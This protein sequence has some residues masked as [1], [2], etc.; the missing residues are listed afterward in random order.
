MDH[1]NFQITDHVYKTVGDHPIQ[2]SLLIPKSIVE[3]GSKDKHPVILRWH[4]GY[5][6]TGARKSSFWAPQWVADLALERSAYLISADYRLMPEA[7]GRDI[8]DDL[9]DVVRW[10][11]N[12]LPKVLQ[13]QSLA[14][15]TTR[16]LVVG[17]SAGGWCA[18]QSFLTAS[19]VHPAVKFQAA[20]SQYGIMD[21]KARFFSEA[22]DKTIMGNPQ[23]PRSVPEDHVARVKS[24]QTPKVVSNSPIPARLDLAIS[25]I[26]HGLFTEYLGDNSLLNPTENVETYKGAWPRVLLIHGT[27]DSA[28]PV[29]QSERFCEKVK[30][31]AGEDNVR[32][33][34]RKDQE[35]MFDVALHL[36]EPWLKQSVGWVA[37]LW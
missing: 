15:D 16:V 6:V 24:G 21:T 23:K 13:D 28:V 27:G 12:T 17:E 26:Q 30:Q 29:D 4:G 5:L 33:V 25:I 3:L 8:L 10:I 32:L 35:H 34:I 22:Y 18:V 31:S 11:G 7:A 14:V 36:H 9:H 37:Q 1:P 20:I 19:S 2:L